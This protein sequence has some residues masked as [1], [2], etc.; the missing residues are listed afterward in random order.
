MIAIISPAKTLDFETHVET[1]HTLPRFKTEANKLIRELR[2]KK[3][4]DIRD[5]MSISEN[6][7][8]LNVE[9]FHNF[10]TTKLPSYAK[11]AVFAFKGDVYRGLE[12]E[13]LDEKALSYLDD[14]LRILSGLYGLLRPLDLIQP[15][16]LE[17]G[18]SLSINGQS[19]LYDFWGTKISRALKKDLKDQGDE[20][21]VNL[22]SQEYAR[23]ANLSSFKGKVIQIEFRDFTNGEYKIVAVY[24]KK[25]RGLMVR[26]MAE[27]A[28]GKSEDLKGFD[29]EGYA[30]DDTSSDKATYV[31]KRG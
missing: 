14:H 21:I 25:A 1:T 16:R 6:L 2:K 20:I 28:I 26:Y 23:A 4:S 19:S 22:A 10:S 18:T 7:A 8:E 27:N 31:F 3:T 17:M 11:P 15:Y 9:R 13:T 29:Y 24:A 12:I 30:F 5:L